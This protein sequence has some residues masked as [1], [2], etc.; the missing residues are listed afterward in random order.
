MLLDWGALAPDSRCGDFP[1]SPLVLF[2]ESVLVRVEMSSEVPTA[3]RAEL[4]FHGPRAQAFGTRLDRCV[5]NSRWWLCDWAFG[6]SGKTA[7]HE[8]ADSS[9]DC[10]DNPRY[11]GKNGCPEEAEEA[12]D[13]FKRS[14]GNTGEVPEDYYADGNAQQKVGKKA[15]HSSRRCSPD[16][17]SGHYGRKKQ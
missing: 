17:Q 3:T 12:E 13:S 14:R 10:A 9:A 7:A 15:H 16:N 11:H 2:R 4:H 6:V 8:T 1:S 5:L